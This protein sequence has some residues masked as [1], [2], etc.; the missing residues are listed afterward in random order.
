MPGDSLMHAGIF[1]FG[2]H[3]IEIEL[4][5]LSSWNNIVTLEKILKENSGLKILCN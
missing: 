3:T 4:L 5:K 2:D 1:A